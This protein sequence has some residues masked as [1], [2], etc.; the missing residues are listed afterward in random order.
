MRLL[1]DTHT[2]LWFVEGDPQLSATARQQLKDENKEIWLSLTSV[3]EMAITFSIGK[4]TQ[5]DLT[6]PFGA[7]VTD[8]LHRN[9]IAVLPITLTHVIQVA[10]LPFYHRDP[11]D[12]LLVAQSLVEQMPI[13][14]ADAVMDSYGIQ[15]LWSCKRARAII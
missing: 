9:G 1:A 10:S 7:Q 11:F 13:V 4:L 2:F 3:W 14:G 12:R 5:L 8:L 6:K 15:R